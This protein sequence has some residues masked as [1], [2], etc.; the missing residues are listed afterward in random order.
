MENNDP[1]TEGSNVRLRVPNRTQ[2]A[3]KVESPDD[4][5]PADH[6]ARAVW[7]VVDSMDL[8][9]FREPIKAREGVGG[10]DATDPRLLVSLWLYATIRAIGSARE[11]ARLCLESKPYLWLCG[12]VTLN[13]HLLSDF[14]VEHGAALDALFTRSIAMLVKKGLVK[15]KR[16][17]QSLP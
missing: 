6:Q 11:L 3:M 4:L 13:H 15:V 14:R 1:V 5:I 9:A 17:S 2:M 8:S 10:R 12:G 16:I 7:Q